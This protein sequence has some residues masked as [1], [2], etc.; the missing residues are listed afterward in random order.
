MP[1]ITTL[2]LRVGVLDS[3][4]VRMPDKTADPIYHTPEYDAWREAVIAKAHGRCQDPLCKYPHRRGIRLFADHIKELQDGG[5]PFD[6][7]NGLARC[8]SCHTRKT[9]EVRAMRMRAPV[10]PKALPGG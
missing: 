4:R 3:N 10:G 7:A 2:G 9:A 8:G 5:A 6:E 1:R